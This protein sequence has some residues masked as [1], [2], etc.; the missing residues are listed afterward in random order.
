[1][2]NEELC[3]ALFRAFAD[4]DESGASWFRYTRAI[5]QACT[6]I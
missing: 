4:G 5:L 6:L 3:Q 2:E 1:M